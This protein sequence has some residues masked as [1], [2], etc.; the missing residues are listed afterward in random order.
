MDD[1]KEKSPT[2]ITEMPLVVTH[3]QEQVLLTRFEAARQ[4]Y[5]ACLGECERRR[6]LLRESKQYQAARKMPK[7]AATKGKSKKNN[8]KDKKKRSSSN[9]ARTKAFQVARAAVG[10]REYDIHSWE[11]KIQH[12]FGDHIDANTGQKLASRAFQASKRVLF[13]KAKRVRF[14]GPN[15]LD[16]VEGKKN[17]SGIRW[18]NNQVVWTGLILDPIIDPDDVYIKYGLNSR[19]KFLR[20]VRRKM[21]G[22]NFFYVQLVNEGV[23]YFD[24]ERHKFGIGTVG[25]DLGPSTIAIVSENTAILK[26]FCS[27]LKS[28]EHTTRR[29]N[30]MMAR[31][32]RANNPHNYEPDFVKNGRK[33]KGKVKKGAKDW[34]D[35]NNYLKIAQQAAEVERKL[36]AQRKTIQNTLARIVLAMGDTYNL[37]NLSY[38]GFQR[39][40]GK[41]VG[42][43]APG[44]F[45]KRLKTIAGTAGLTV[46]EFST[47]NTKLSQRCIC[48]R[49]Q[50]KS[51][52]CR[53]HDCPCGVYA[54]RDLFSAF[55]ARF[56]DSE[57]GLFHEERARSAYAQGWDSIL[58]T[59]WNHASTNYNQS[60]IGK[61]LPL[62]Q[63]TQR[64]S[65]KIVS[66]FPGDN[67]SE[68]WNVVPSRKAS[69]SPEE[70]Q[71]TGNSVI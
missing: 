27:E 23:P 20:I 33:K 70:V 28:K 14:K 45:V 65:E 35:S 60:S 50:K 56:V 1:E 66:D 44:M 62:D 37:E 26:P 13:G 22:R 67:W 40:F 15:Q 54:Q 19:I 12:H 55:L 53:V 4:L 39:L 2:F 58:Y 8:K 6:K 5:N 25:M 46:N 64:A 41:S 43:R 11:K 36:A 32:R 17:D 42:R 71:G 51:L 52:G 30:R 49:V 16:S 31:Q 38:Y 68:V 63:R 18:K 69:E 21:K 10:Y 61:A 7:V 34:V 48:G 47:Y 57:T 9:P 24:P 29:Y 3:A 59:S